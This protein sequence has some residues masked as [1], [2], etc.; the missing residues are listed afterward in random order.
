MCPNINNKEVIQQFNEIVESLGG[1]PL[2]TE[3]FKS[4]ELRAQREGIN[5]AAMEAAYRIWDANNGYEIDKTPNGQPSKLFSDLLR[6]YNGNRV[7]AI[8]AKAKTF[9]NA[10]KTQ[11][12]D[13]LSKSKSKLEKNIIQN[14]E[15]PIEAVI[16]DNKNNDNV[17]KTNNNIYKQKSSK[18]AY[19][20]DDL[21]QKW[22]S[23][24]QRSLEYY[25]TRIKNN[26]N[27][28]KYDS[29]D[30]AESVKSQLNKNY[31]NLKAYVIATH[32]GNIYVKVS[33]PQIG[34][35]I[36]KQ[37]N[38]LI[39]YYKGLSGDQ[40]KSDKLNNE[41]DRNEDLRHDAILNYKKTPSDPS[42]KNRIFKGKSESTVGEIL[43]VLDKLNPV[44]SYVI[45][46]ILNGIPADVKNKKIICTDFSTDPRIDLDI[47]IG[48]NPAYYDPKTDTI[49]ID[50]K[51]MFPSKGGVG[52]ADATVLHEIL[53]SALFSIIHSNNEVNHKLQDILDNATKQL[54]QKYG[55]SKEQLLNKDQ[56]FYGLTNIDEF[57]SELWTNSRFIR[58]L[59][60]IKSIEDTKQS[61]LDQFVTFLL[62]LFGITDK[63]NAFVEAHQFIVDIFDNYS[64]YSGKDYSNSVLD[65]NYSLFTQQPAQLSTDTNDFVNKYKQMSEQIEFHEDTHTYVNKITG[66]I[67]RPVSDVKT[68]CGYGEQADKLPEEAQKLGDF[69]AKIGTEIHAAFSA[70]LLNKFKQS[71]YPNLSKSTINSINNIITKLRKKYQIISS[72]Q[73]LFNDALNIAGTADLI[74]KD[75]A[76][77]K[78]I[79]LD[80][81]TKVRNIGS[82]KKSGFSYYHSS[83]FGKPDFDKHNFQ[84]TMYEQLHNMLGLKIDER[85]IIPIEYDATEDGKVEKLYYTSKSDGTTLEEKGYF[86]IPHRTYIDNDI[87]KLVINNENAEDLSNTNLTEQIQLIDKILNSTKNKVI[88]L[89]TKG[90]VVQA[91][92]LESLINSFN[93][94]SEKEIIVAYIKSALE[95]LQNI[96]NGKN[97]YSEKLKLEN[98]NRPAWNLKQLSNWKEVAE[99]YQ[100]LD[101]LQNYILDNPNLF[102]KEDYDN[103]LLCLSQAIQYRTRLESAYNRKGK[104]LWIKWLQPFIKNIEI[105]YKIKAEREFKKKYPKGSKKEMNQ[106]IQDYIRNNRQIINKETHEFIE[107]QSISASKDI[108]GFYR[109]VD[110]IFQSK[111]PIISGMAMAYDQMDSLTREQFT[112]QYRKLVDLTK[113]FEQTYGGGDF[114]NSKELYSFMLDFSEDGTYLIS[115]IPHSFMVE[116]KKAMQ[117]IQSD[118]QYSSSV[119]KFKA[120]MQWLKENAPIKDLV[121]Y[122]DAKIKAIEEFLLDQN[123]TEQE[124]DAIISNEK[125]YKNKKSYSELVKDGVI[126]YNRAEQIRQIIEEVT[127]KYRQIDKKKFPNKKWEEMQQLKEKNP[128]DV[129]Y[130]LFKTIQHMS[131]FG[132]ER[133]SK[134][135]KLNGRI[136]GVYKTYG[137]RVASGQNVKDIA[138]DQISRDFSFR[139]D[140]TLYGQYEFTDQNNNPVNFVPVFYTNQ[141]PDA[142]QSYDLPTIYLKWYKSALKYTNTMQI[143]DYLEYTKYV[144]NTRKTESGSLNRMASMW[145]KMH[146]DSPITDEK[147]NKGTSNLASQLNDWFDMVVY[148]KKQDSLGTLGNVDIGKVMN[149]FQ[150]YASLRVMG[151]NYISMVNNAAMAEVAQATEVMAKKYIDPESYTRA[152][153]EYAF[154]LPNILGDVGARK[155]TSKTNLLNE[156]FGTLET[157]DESIRSKTKLNKLFNSSTLYFTTSVGEHEAQ[158]RFMLGSLIKQRAYDINGNDI[159]SIY[160]YYTVENGELIFDKDGKVNNWKPEQRR[161]FSAT[162]RSNLMSMHGNYS[163]KDVVALQRNGYLKLALMFRK[164]IVPTF[165]KRFDMMYIDNVTQSDTEGYYRTAGRIAT[166]KVKQFFYKFIDE[167]KALAM[168]A[169]ADYSTLTETEKQNL[170]RFGTEMTIYGL[171]F[172]L[173]NVLKAAADG[174]DDDNYW[175]NNTLYQ[176]YRLRTDIGFYFNPNDFIKIVQSPFPSTSIFKNTSTLFDNIMDPTAR[177]ERGPWKDHLKIEK[178][179]YNLL[180]VVRQTYRYR[181]IE[182]EFNMF[183]LQ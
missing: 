117:S 98:E 56:L 179:L 19:T 31:P 81:K 111:D 97:G 34:D 146:P 164:W 166:Y 176:L 162:L 63:N 85:G 169:N 39:Q 26:Y 72:E 9:S 174:G 15:P 18:V 175:L 147:V 148:G 29:F 55:M 3:E 65:L 68:E 151:L 139:A 170:S 102:E 180:P 140:D 78:I 25:N 116:Y 160:D 60:N 156:L 95:S 114:S 133:I 157:Q 106:Y 46:K 100:Q 163:E 32:Y 118:T 10:F 80:F 158:S 149:V 103:I 50:E 129:R 127:W 89:Y 150:K 52:K 8:Q 155:V 77:G 128:D 144:V 35:F 141:L 167:N 135:Y 154:D 115:E 27:N 182:T 14:N 28:I 123:A 132:D 138:K 152:T 16:D 5:Y 1:S 64:Y 54:E 66:N 33:K 69:T 101:D 17:S 119:E 76:T 110:T 172:V 112:V 61:M 173:Y 171:L 75:K 21:N 109:Y 142:D 183:Q 44:Q 42:L 53:H 11:F 2:T 13:Q 96:M 47:I 136:P 49:Y 113:E 62:R 67:Y 41:N 22:R 70:M 71:D 87:D 125:K 93:S 108:N 20:I 43:K 48:R 153:K 36:N 94:M 122:R 105:S 168:A 126:T 86:T 120:K 84:L 30:Q 99:S 79:L 92:E 58:E 24:Y 73:I 137:E 131:E 82:T 90:K 40:R 7:L 159:G 6:H 4:K 161:A 45:R 59:A 91:Q 23:E 51:G 57:V 181:D 134:N 37:N 83:K 88:S 12:E 121:A 178:T 107:A 177:Y 104:E 143:L 38:E 165:R 130:K 74:V 145:K 124:I